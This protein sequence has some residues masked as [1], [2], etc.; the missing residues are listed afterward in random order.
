MIMY[1]IKHKDI[2]NLSYLF[3]NVLTEDIESERVM[4]EEYIDTNQKKENK[5]LESL[6]MAD[7]VV[8]E[9]VWQVEGGRRKGNLGINV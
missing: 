2:L 6:P 3:Q 8:E 4:E 5:P 1:I 7:R 9:E